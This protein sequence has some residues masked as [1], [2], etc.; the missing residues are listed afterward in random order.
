MQDCSVAPTGL[1]YF[2]VMKQGLHPCLKSIVPMGLILG[3]CAISYIIAFHFSL[4]TFHSSLPYSP[5]VQ[6]LLITTRIGH[7]FGVSAGEV[8]R[9]AEIF[10]SA[11]VEIVVLLGI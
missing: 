9:A 8:M 5:L 1:K 4:F 11:E 10:L 7:V 3:L 2:A 6:R